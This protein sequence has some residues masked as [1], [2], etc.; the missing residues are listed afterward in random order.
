M[1]T[2]ANTTLQEGFTIELPDSFVSLPTDSIDEAALEFVSA[3]I[4]DALGLDEA[5]KD[6]YA[7]SQLFAAA[8]VVAGEFEVDTVSIGFF[9]APPT[10]NATVADPVVLFLT[11]TSFQAEAA[12]IDVAIEGLKDIAETDTKATP[13]DVRLPCGR[14]VIAAS[15]RTVVL[16]QEGSTDTPLL[17][18]SLTLWAPNP[19]TGQVAVVHVSTNNWNH[20]ER[21]CETSMDIFET[22]DWA[23]V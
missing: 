14:A 23:R 5:D 20:W 7:A 13:F 10:S 18:R 17:Q 21:V 19:A 8:G 1:T 3:E 11:T 15:E 9:L 12:D 4:A 22:L 2:A 6:S 16:E